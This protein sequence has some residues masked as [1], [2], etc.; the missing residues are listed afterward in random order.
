VEIMM[1]NSIEAERARNGMSKEELATQ[2]GISVKTYYNWLN[3]VNP[4]PSTALI[5]M[6]DIF[7]V[8]I[9][10]LLNRDEQR[11]AV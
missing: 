11:K 3:G 1:F 8:T 2:I 6:S 4:I 10:Y 5:K 7:G 9:D